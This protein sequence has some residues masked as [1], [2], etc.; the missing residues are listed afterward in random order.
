MVRMT[1][2]L[3]SR[4]AQFTN[5]LGD[6]ELDLRGNQISL[7]ENLA[8]SNNLFDVLDISEN[9]IAILGNMPYL[10]RLKTIL[11]GLNKITRVGK[12]FAK[13]VPNLESLIL[14]GN[15]IHSLESLSDLF[16]LKKLERLTLVD[17]PVTREGHYRQYIIKMIPSLR[18]LDYK[19]IKMD[20]REHANAL[21]SGEDGQLLEKKLGKANVREF[22]PGNLGDTPA[23]KPTPEQI[24]AVKL[25]IQNARSVEEISQLERALRSGKIEEA[26][27]NGTKA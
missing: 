15:Q 14:S 20:E 21:F 5:C 9:S 16:H 6:R 25:K 12:G 7:V 24:A 10:P 4:S 19:K 26:L 11:A 13:A 22:T 1:P 3:I 27:L 17:N 2:E 23:Y 8:T 18:V